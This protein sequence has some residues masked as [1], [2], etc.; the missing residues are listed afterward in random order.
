ML[1]IKIEA[2]NGLYHTRV[3]EQELRDL[4]RGIGGVRDRFLVVQRIPDRPGFFVQTWHEHGGSYQFECRSGTA[5]THVRAD[6][7]SPDLVADA[8]ARW[9]RQEPEWDAGIE[10]ESAGMSAEEP[11][12]ELDDEIRGELEEEI[13]LALRGGYDTVATL[14][15]TAEERLAE[16]SAGPVGAAQARQLVE[17]LWLERVEEQERWTDVTGADRLERAFAA[18]EEGGITAREHFACCRSCGVGEIHA[19]GRADARGFVFF[20]AQSTEWAVK[21][22]GL[23]LYYG[24]FDE[25][26]ETT[27]AVGREVVAGLRAAGLAVEWNGAPDRAI[28]VPEIDWRKRLIG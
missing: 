15:E 20:H 19:D 23:T 14:T 8:M 11:A 27:A 9:A 24:G 13:R 1:E 25:S 21:T 7:D 6:L 28:E 3:S 16:K 10:W 5:V 26:E 2:E 12:P 17:R 22:G 18:L 4:V